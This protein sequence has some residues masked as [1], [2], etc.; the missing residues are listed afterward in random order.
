MRKRWKIKITILTV[1][2]VVLLCFSY[3]IYLF[4][5]CGINQPTIKE[6]YY[7]SFTSKKI[8]VVDIEKQGFFI[9]NAY[10]I[11]TYDRVLLRF[12]CVYTVP[13]S[14]PGILSECNYDILDEKGNSLTQYISVYSERHGWFTGINFSLDFEK[15]TF[16]EIVDDE[17]SVVISAV[18]NE[19]VEYAYCKFK[20]SVSS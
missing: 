15:N 8:D 6:N 11:E 20:L 14:K 12:R 16:I 5:N 13:F 19:G 1:V 9:S 4:N 2:F 18:D 17:I 10:Y 3:R 7:E